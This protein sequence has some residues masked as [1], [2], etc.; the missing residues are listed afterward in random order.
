MRTEALPSIN[1]ITITNALNT[2]TQIFQEPQFFREPGIELRT[3]REPGPSY[4]MLMRWSN[5]NQR[6]KLSLYL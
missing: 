2:N 5:N 1:P 4:G 3:V 6:Q